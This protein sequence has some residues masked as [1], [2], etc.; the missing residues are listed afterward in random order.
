MSELNH[1]QLVTVIYYEEASLVIKHDIKTF[2]VSP[3][4][5]IVLPECYKEGK[6]VIA[7]CEGKINVLNKVGDR[8]LPNDATNM[9]GQA[10]ASCH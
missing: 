8:I 2:K 7:V 3:N 9:Q 6:S 1:Q 10:L 5:R 4:G